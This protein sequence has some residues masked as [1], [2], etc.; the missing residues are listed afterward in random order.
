MALPLDISQYKSKPIYIRPHKCPFYV[1]DR[2]IEFT[3]QNF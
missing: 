2:F 1:D 3:L